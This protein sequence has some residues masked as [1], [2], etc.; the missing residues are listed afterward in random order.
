VRKSLCIFLFGILILNIPITAIVVGLDKSMLGITPGDSF[1][2]EVMENPSDNNP[3][4][5]N[6]DFQRPEGFTRPEDLTRPE[7]EQNLGGMF[8]ANLQL[9]NYILF[10]EIG[11]I[12]STGI[13][14]SVKIVSTPNGSTNGKIDI[15]IRGSKD[16]YETDFSYGSPVVFTDWDGWVEILNDL[17]VNAA[18][19]NENIASFSVEITTNSE[20][21]FQTKIIIDMVIAEER[22]E[23]ISEMQIIQH[24]RYDKATGIQDLILVESRTVTSFMGEMVQKFHIEFTTKGLTPPDYSS[25]L[26]IVG[27]GTITAL[28][29][30]AFVIKRRRYQFQ[31]IKKDI[32]HIQEETVK[33]ERSQLQSIQERLAELE[34]RESESL[35]KA[36]DALK[37]DPVIRRR[38]R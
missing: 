38:R 19:S 36:E 31:D 2:V 6:G 29:V 34:K 5:G 12:P 4:K 10:P 32:V 26:F 20:T 18:L 9:E 30:G 35:N 3:K 16:S 7:G 14:F 27:L 17:E 22:Q 28:G 15:S 1:N 24:V 25:L 21:T 23:F 33:K 11:Q 13:V 37:T 8:F